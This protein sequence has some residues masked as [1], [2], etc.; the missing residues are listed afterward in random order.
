MGPDPGWEPPTLDPITPIPDL[1]AISHGVGIV[2]VTPVAERRTFALSHEHPTNSGCN[3]TRDL[4]R[5][6]FLFMPL[7]GS[8]LPCLFRHELPAKFH[9][10]NF[11]LISIDKKKDKYDVK[12]KNPY[13]R[14]KIN[15]PVTF[16]ANK[17]YD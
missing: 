2:D 14:G 13:F 15:E 9:F 6:T 16:Y 4:V 8:T 3:C 5:H 11:L 1:M 17:G 10:G 7:V 12:K